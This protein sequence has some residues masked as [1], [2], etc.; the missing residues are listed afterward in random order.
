MAL[1]RRRAPARSRCSS[2]SASRI[3]AWVAVGDLREFAR[4]CRGSSSSGSTVLAGTGLARA[5]EVHAGG[6]EHAASRSRARRR[7]CPRTRQARAAARRSPCRRGRGRSSGG[8]LLGPRESGAGGT[9]ERARRRSI[10]RAVVA[11]GDACCLGDRSAIGRRTSAAAARAWPQGRR[12]RLQARG[13]Q[14]AA[15]E[16]L[17]PA[18]NAVSD[19]DGTS[20]RGLD[21]VHCKPSM[22]AFASKGRPA[23]HRCPRGAGDRGVTVARLESVAAGVPRRCAPWRH[24]SRGSAQH[25]VAPLRQGALAARRLCGSR[26][27]RAA[28]AARRRHRSYDRSSETRSRSFRFARRSTASMIAESRRRRSS[29]RKLRALGIDLIFDQPTTAADDDGACSRHS[30]RSARPW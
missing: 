22:V 24:C 1:A 30:T 12:R 25:H 7:D 11:A 6:R 15:D 20:E 28:R 23:P 8:R 18:A 16:R 26:I 4:R 13:R 21:R 29:G 27:S 10:A 3:E 17:T 19:R 5:R 9:R 14:Y 2:A